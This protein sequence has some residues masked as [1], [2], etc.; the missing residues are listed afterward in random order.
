MIK[1]SKR[2]LPLILSLLLSS[3]VLVACNDSASVSDKAVSPDSTQTETTLT[4]NTTNEQKTTTGDI[5]G[6]DVDQHGCQS[7]AGYSWCAKTNQ[8]ERPWELA[9]KQSF[10][11]TEEAFTAFCAGTEK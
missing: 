7:S 8:C 5:V 9:K 6:G 1:S 11:N 3:V 10:D 2:S 4:D